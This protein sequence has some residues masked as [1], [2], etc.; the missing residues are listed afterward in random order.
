MNIHLNQKKKKHSTLIYAFNKAS[1][2]HRYYRGAKIK[3]KKKKNQ[4]LQKNLNCLNLK[5][6]T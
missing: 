1:T 6:Q 2:Y 4:Y 3:E 5:R